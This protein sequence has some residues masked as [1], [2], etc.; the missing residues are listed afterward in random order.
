MREVMEMNKQL[1]M[2]AVQPQMTNLLASA[3]IGGKP[4]AAA[5]PQSMYGKLDFQKIM[6]FNEDMASFLKDFDKA[7]KGSSSSSVIGSNCAG[8]GSAGSQSSARF[9]KPWQHETSQHMLDLGS[10]GKSR[11]DGRRRRRP[12]SPQTTARRNEYPNLPPS[13]IHFTRWSQ[14]RLTWNGK[15]RMSTI[16]S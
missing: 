10:T 9:S 1:A 7:M 8:S 13:R 6:S 12:M 11:R 16:Q 3:A 2:V 14:L 4:R 5:Q 15:G